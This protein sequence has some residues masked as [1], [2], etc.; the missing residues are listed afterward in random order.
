MSRDVNTEDRATEWRCT[1]CRC[2]GEAA[3]TVSSPSAD[4]PVAETGQWL[5]RAAVEPLAHPPSEHCRSPGVTSWA[6]VREREHSACPG[7][8]DIFHAAPAPAPSTVVRPSTFG[9][10]LI[11]VP[12]QIWNG[13]DRQVNKCLV[14]TATAQPQSALLVRVAHAVLCH[15]HLP[16]TSGLHILE[17]PAARVMHTVYTISAKGH[18]HDQGGRTRPDGSAVSA[19]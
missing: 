8:I 6:R 4:R 10:L 3:E 13:S 16:C 2:G 1:H 15:A 9:R 18:D 12:P 17:A 7:A 5:N 19:G 14:K 11:L